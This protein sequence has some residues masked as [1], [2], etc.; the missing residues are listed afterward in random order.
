[1]LMARF[2]G[3]RQCNVDLF[4]ASLEAGAHRRELV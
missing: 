3:A 1:M 4:G 2:E